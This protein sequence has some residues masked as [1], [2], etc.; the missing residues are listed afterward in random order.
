VGEGYFRHALFHPLEDEA[1]KG[2]E[3]V[4]MRGYVSVGWLFYVPT[5]GEK[6]GLNTSLLDRHTDHGT[7]TLLFSVPIIALQI[8]K[9]GEWKFVP[10][11]RG[12]LVVNLG[13]CLEGEC[14]TPWTKSTVL[15]IDTVLSA[16]HLKATLHKVSEPPAD[17]LHEKRLSLVQFN[18]SRGDMRL[19]PIAG[20]CSI[21]THCTSV[22][23]H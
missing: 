5:F 12:A 7:T 1:R 10:Y 9:D 16:G 20:I 18:A 3:G 2:S 22:T 23:I 17:Q 14:A 13:E 6:I 15:I 8:W 21:S 19:K 4:R 11:R